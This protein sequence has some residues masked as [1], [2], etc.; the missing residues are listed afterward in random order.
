MLFD[1]WR[2]LRRALPFRLRK[3]AD[4]VVHRSKQKILFSKARTDGESRRQ[5]GCWHSISNVMHRSKHFDKE[6]ELE[7]TARS[8]L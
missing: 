8:L 2:S 1:E 4:R 5:K 3:L 6:E 7:W